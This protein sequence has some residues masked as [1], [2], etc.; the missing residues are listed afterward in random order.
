VLY[1]AQ[2]I[3]HDAGTGRPA[4][5]TDPRT[6]SDFQTAIRKEATGGFGGVGFVFSIDDPFTGIDLDHCRDPEAGVITPQAQE[7]ITAL[8]SY[9][10]IS[11]SGT[12]VHVIV[13]ACLPAGGR[14][15]VG[16]HEFYSDGRY[17]TTTGDHLDGTPTT[18][19]DR[20]EQLN[21]VTTR[22]FPEKKN[23]NSRRTERITHLTDDEILQAATTARNGDRFSNFLAFYTGN[24]AGRI[25][26]LLR[27]SGLM[28]DKWEREDYRERTIHA[29]IEATTET[30][31]PRV[32]GPPVE[33]YQ[34]KLGRDEKAEQI[35]LPDFPLTDSGNA[36]LFAHLYGDRV[37]YSHSRK[38]FLIWDKHWWR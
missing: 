7:I 2:K 38:R 14:R 34:S 5:T 12:G 21:A 8:N 15:R 22:I 26:E 18:I 17:F 11:P 30:W 23:G 1:D 24:D 4:S 19:E 6:W 9:I 33:K 32:S 13:K 25:D 36:E 20:Q 3:P 10:E 37:R 29:A 31:T 16:N 28:R 35:E 27:Q